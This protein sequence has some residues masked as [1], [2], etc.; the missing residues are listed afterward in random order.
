[1]AKQSVHRLHLFASASALNHRSSLKKK[2]SR[3]RQ[4]A[5]DHMQYK[6][7]SDD[8]CPITFIPVRE[9]AHPVGFDPLHAF[10]CDAVVCW[11]T[12]NRACNPI[13]LAP[14]RGRVSDVLQPLIV[15]SDAHV[16][17]TLT[18]LRRAGH[19]M[20]TKAARI[21]HAM[22]AVAA[23]FLLF[24]VAILV[25][26]PFHATLFVSALSFVHLTHHTC[27]TY[28]RDGKALLASFLAL[29]LQVMHLTGTVAL[30]LCFHTRVVIAQTLVLLVRLSID[31]RQQQMRS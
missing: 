15:H 13:T 8:V 31:I 12:Q 5:T 6:G 29:I 17:D 21:R 18:Q 27:E 24:Q 19:V 11:I 28:P 7:D 3:E 16:V 10:E 2:R 30:K 14:L 1:M 9:L 23:N 25:L 20:P 4:K 26:W 22:W